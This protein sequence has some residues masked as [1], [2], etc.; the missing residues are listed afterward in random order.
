MDDLDAVAKT[1]ETKPRYLLVAVPPSVLD[2]RERLG[3]RKNLVD[4]RV[5]LLTVDCLACCCSPSRVCLH[6]TGDLG[7]LYLCDRREVELTGAYG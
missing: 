5:D 4:L 2:H 6:T 7:F 3:P 1:F